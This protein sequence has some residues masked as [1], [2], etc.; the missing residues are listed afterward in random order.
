MDT[1]HGPRILVV[2]D[3]RKDMDQTLQAIR[4]HCS[5][6]E[7]RIA[8]GAW[9]GLDYLFARGRFH[10]RQRHPLPDVVLLAVGMQH[11]DGVEVLKRINEAEYL[12]KI[13]VALLCETED[14]KRRAI[15]EGVPATAL[16]MK[17]ISTDNLREVLRSRG[18]L[19]S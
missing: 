6:Y 16:L 4:T 19:A 11:I 3:D 14:E 13:P 5:S 17:P 8:D 2:D 15:R 1:L 12:R 10:E 9:E 7:A 18:A